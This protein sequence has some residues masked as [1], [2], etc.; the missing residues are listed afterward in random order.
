MI[1]FFNSWFL[2]HLCD[3]MKRKIWFR[4]LFSGFQVWS[5]ST[6]ISNVAY[7]ILGYSGSCSTVEKRDGCSR[8]G[9][10]PSQAK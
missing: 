4:L 6:N 8:T 9:N 2:K 7:G 3:L 10:V 1:S 5:L